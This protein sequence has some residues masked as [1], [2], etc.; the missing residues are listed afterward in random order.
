MIDIKQLTQQKNELKEVWDY[1]G[2]DS[3]FPDKQV[4]Q[5]LLDY[6]ADMIQ[7]AIRV[8]ANKEGRVDEPVRFLAGVLRKSKERNMTPEER[9]EEIST[10]RSVVGK[11]GVAKKHALQVA[12]IKQEFAQVCS[13]LPSV[14]QTLPT[15]AQSD[16]EGVGFGV[17]VSDGDSDSARA[18]EK[19]KPAPPT[20][21]VSQPPTQR[22]E[23]TKTNT[24]PPTVSG[25]LPEK[26]Q[27][28]PKPKTIKTARGEKPK[29]DGF[30]TWT[31]V[32]RTEWI[33]CTLDCYESGWN[34]E[35]MTGCAACG[36]AKAAAA[37]ESLTSENQIKYGNPLGVP[38]L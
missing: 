16:C 26:R 33:A 4:R 17:C 1:L 29:P 31:N 11:I 38:E 15:F 28:K 34:F 24:N 23:K 30:D 3:A 32:E 6:P 10:L 13:D 12:A 27:D 18:V 9:E 19:S 20:A 2:I 21:A 36:Q 22:E 7:S 25:V 5:W 35:H 8:L 14:C 37:G